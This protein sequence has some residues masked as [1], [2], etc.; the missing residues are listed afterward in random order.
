MEEYV[1]S[2]S[3]EAFAEVF[4]RY[5]PRIRS[6]LLKR[7]GDEALAEDLTQNIFV[8]ILRNAHKFDPRRDFSTW[9]FT[10][11]NNVL[12]NHYRTVSRNRLHCFS[13]VAPR[14][15]ERRAD[16]I[17]T[18]PSPRSGPDAEA[19]RG[20]LRAELARALEQLDPALRDPFLLYQVEGIPFPEIA[21]QL[22]ISLHAARGRAQRARRELKQVLQ[23]V[24]GA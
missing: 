15:A 24:V 7:L 1:R 9:A 20:E 8:R 3:E 21:S 2:G 16:P 12:K 22:E 14:E 13:D 17:A 4:E 18:V 11:V 6:F 10:I 19:Y 5:R 23:A